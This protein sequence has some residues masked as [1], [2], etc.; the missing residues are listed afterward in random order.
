MP[1]NPASYHVAEGMRVQVAQTEGGGQAQ[2]FGRMLATV[3]LQGVTG[4]MARPSPN[5]GKT[6]GYQTWQD[7]RTLLTTFIHL[8]HTDNAHDYELRLYNW[9]DDIAWS[10]LPVQF[11][12]DRTPAAPMFYTYNFVFQTLGEVPAPKDVSGLPAGQSPD[13]ITQAQQ[14]LGPQLVGIAQTLNLHSALA[15]DLIT[16]HNLAILSTQEQALI[17]QGGYYATLLSSETLTSSNFPGI[18]SYTGYGQSPRPS[19]TALYILDSL[20]APVTS[21]I[22]LAVNDQLAQ[23]PAPYADVTNA[24]SQ[25]ATLQSNLQ[26]AYPS[27]SPVYLMRELDALRV[28]LSPLVGQSQLFQS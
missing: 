10:V 17:A 21:A 6:D 8:S 19:G 1:I 9:T 22:N 27:G 7:L 14:N 18:G 28:G 11:T 16:L 24:Q 2:T 13:P 3:T 20:I 4:W 15:K 25:L 5:G 26:A 12:L 23:I